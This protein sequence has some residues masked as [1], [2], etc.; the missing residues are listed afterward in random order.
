M[1]GNLITSLIGILF[2][3]HALCSAHLV[4]ARE[5]DKIAQ[6]STVKTSHAG[7]YVFNHL[8]TGHFINILEHAQ[9]SAIYSQD[10]RHGL[11]YNHT[12]ELYQ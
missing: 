5:T 12:L 4:L 8:F 9:V 2:F 1:I 6:G 11:Q 7:W 10:K 3:T